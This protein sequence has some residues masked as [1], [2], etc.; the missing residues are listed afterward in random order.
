MKITLDTN[1]HSNKSLQIEPLMKTITIIICTSIFCGC[2]QKATEPKAQTTKTVVKCQTVA[3]YGNIDICN[4]EIENMV[5]CSSNE[6]I[7]QREESLPLQGSITLGYYIPKEKFENIDK[8]KKLKISDVI[9]IYAPE[10]YSNTFFGTK[11]L[12]STFTVLKN[13]YIIAKWDSLKSNIV[14]KNLEFEL[15]QP[16]LVD[17]YCLNDKAKSAII[18]QRASNE[19]DEKYIVMALNLM[20]CKSRLIFLTYYLEYTGIETVTKVKAKNDYFVLRF[21]EANN[22][23]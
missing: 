15:S 6:R 1:H 16:V 21:L 18:L 7:K 17:S 19:V 12:N 3:K 8:L 23:L 20:E 9:K 2:S 22:N 5:E 14:E 13:N 4:P 11:E 10:A